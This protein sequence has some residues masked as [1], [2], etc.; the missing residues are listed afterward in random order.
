MPLLSYKLK[1]EGS[2]GLFFYQKLAAPYI[3]N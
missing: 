1:K 3:P 2:L